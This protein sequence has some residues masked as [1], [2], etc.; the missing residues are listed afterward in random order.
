V[1]ATG[2]F[3]NLVVLGTV[4]HGLAS[5]NAL[6][7]TIASLMLV[8]GLI[9]I[10]R[11]RETLH[12]WTMISAF[13][14]SVA[15]LASYL[16]GHMV[17]IDG[18]PRFQ[19]VPFTGP[20]AVRSVYLAVLIPHVILA[21]LVPVLALVTIYLGL[22]DRRAAHRRLAKWTYPIWMYVS[23]SGIVIYVMLFHLYPRP[24]G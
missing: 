22:R 21:A 9:A 20:A 16:A 1:I 18:V 19:S 24:E 2:A 7:N 8:A 10:K 12:K 5:L 17:V 13:F 15:F 11:R 6:L 23:V 3:P 4:W 14:V